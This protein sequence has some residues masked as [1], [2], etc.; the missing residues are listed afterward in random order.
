M[1]HKK[2]NMVSNS[3]YTLRPT[4]AANKEED[5]GSW[6]T[7][8]GYNH[9]Q[10]QF[11]VL[12]L[13]FS[14]RHMPWARHGIFSEKAGKEKGRMKNVMRSQQRCLMPGMKEKEK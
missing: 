10:I 13:Y 1:S 9:I 8:P 4:A 3:F 12:L 2:G 7:A 6:S 14:H 11:Q 5:T